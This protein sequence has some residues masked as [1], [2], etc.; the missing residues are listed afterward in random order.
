MI[1]QFFDI[2]SAQALSTDAGALIVLVI[3]VEE[4]SLEGVTVLP[5][6]PHRDVEF[7]PGSSIAPDLASN[8][9]VFNDLTGN[10][11]DFVI[12]L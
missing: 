8:A 3:G 4:T 9:A 11:A 2:I 7:A 12:E 6:R 1:L 5:D 10:T